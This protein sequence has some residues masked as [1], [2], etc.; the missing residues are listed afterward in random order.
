MPRKCIEGMAGKAQRL[1]ETCHCT[2][3]AAERL[4]CQQAGMELRLL[5]AAAHRQTWYGRWG[6]VFGRGGFAVGKQV[7]SSGRHSRL[8]LVLL[9]KP[10]KG[11]PDTRKA[12]IIRRR[13]VHCPTTRAHS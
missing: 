6:F 3:T 1:C 12:C 8:S 9:R 11:Y 4:P 2:G 7:R 5:H 10:H 13:T